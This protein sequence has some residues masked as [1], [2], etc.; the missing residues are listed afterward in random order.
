MS[1]TMTKTTKTW[2]S[3]KERGK[4]IRQATLENMAYMQ[5]CRKVAAAKIR[6]A[7]TDGVIGGGGRQTQ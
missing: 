6:K 4:K 3:S 7:H 1:M 5:H 2:Q